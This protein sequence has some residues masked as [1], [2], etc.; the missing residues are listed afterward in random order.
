MG[1]AGLLAVTVVLGLAS[2]AFA[3]EQPCSQLAP[4][5]RFDTMVG[6]EAPHDVDL[7]IVVT[8]LDLPVSSW[9]SIKGTYALDTD[10]LKVTLIDLSGGPTEVVM[11]DTAAKLAS[12]KLPVALGPAVLAILEPFDADGHSGH[13]TYAATRVVDA[14]HMKPGMTDT[15]ISAFEWFFVV[16]LFA[17]ISLVAVLRRIHR[18]TNGEVP[19]VI[20]MVLAEALARRARSRDGLVAFVVV[21]AGFAAYALYGNWVVVGS[22]WI[23]LCIGDYWVAARAVTLL[24]QPHA[25]AELYGTNLVVRA[26]DHTSAIL[27]SRR[28]I[29]RAKREALPSA[30]A[31]ALLQ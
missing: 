8:R 28:A 18:G 17:I 9:I 14:Y 30:R 29:K 6:P 22:V 31:R 4:P 2:T 21:L 23:L 25:V 1:R 3:D 16:A 11:F 13:V 27:L 24:E 10:R 20:S 15:L 19:I 7:T 12:C 5:E 26:D